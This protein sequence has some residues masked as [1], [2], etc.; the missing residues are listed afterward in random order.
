MDLVIVIYKRFTVKA[1]THNHNLFVVIRVTDANNL[2]LYIS[3]KKQEM[4][5]KTFFIFLFVRYLIK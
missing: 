4:Y 5:F 3:K 1:A 2:L